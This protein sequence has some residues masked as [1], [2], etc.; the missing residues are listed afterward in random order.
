MPFNIEHD[1]F[2]KLLALSNQQLVVLKYILLHDFVFKGAE[3]ID[4]VIGSA[5]GTVDEY[6][7]A[8]LF[9]KYKAC[10]YFIGLYNIFIE[11]V[12]QEAPA[13]VELYISQHHKMPVT[14]ALAA[15]SVEDLKY[16]NANGLHWVYEN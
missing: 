6:C 5:I 12:F 9:E 11:N 8:V 4:K 16:L 13:V 3:Y 7:D 15:L 14:D 2:K 1:T 10:V